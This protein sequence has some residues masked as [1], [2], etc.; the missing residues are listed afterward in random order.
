MDAGTLTRTFFE[1]FSR[2]DLDAMGSMLADDVSYLM[3]GLQPMNGRDQ[4]LGMYR[5]IIETIGDAQQQ[6][7][8]FVADGNMAA[9]TVSA[10]GGDEAAVAIFHEWSDDGKLLRYR[11]YAN[12]APP[13]FDD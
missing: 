5:T 9:F 2:R 11:G 3:P 13:G 7:F 8:D 6:I 10:P 1:A 12:I 4:V